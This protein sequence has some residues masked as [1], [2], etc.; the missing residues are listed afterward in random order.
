MRKTQCLLIVAILL[1]CTSGA[2]AQNDTLSDGT[3]VEQT[4]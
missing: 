1:L 4:Q 3:I 2:A